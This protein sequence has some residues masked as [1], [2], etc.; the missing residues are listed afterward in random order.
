M[1][2]VSFVFKAKQIFKASALLGPKYKKVI[3]KNENSGHSVVTSNFDAKCQLFESR[4]PQQTY[5]SS[6]LRER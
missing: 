6:L 5:K 3:K 1:W 4:L 2:R